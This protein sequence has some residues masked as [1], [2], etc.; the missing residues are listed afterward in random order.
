[1]II[2]K[3]DKKNPQ[4]FVI[5]LSGPFYFLNVECFFFLF[6]FLLI[7]PYAHISVLGQFH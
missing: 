2:K 6:I 1:M 5:F 7:K 3:K 4:H